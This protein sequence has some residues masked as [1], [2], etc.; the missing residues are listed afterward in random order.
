MKILIQGGRVIDPATQTDTVAD[1]AIADGKIMAIG[2]TPPGF[3][4]DTTIRAKGLVVAPGLVVAGTDSRH[5]EGVADQVYRFMPIRFKREDLARVH[6]TDERISIAQ[7]AD[8]VRFYHR[9]LQQAA[10]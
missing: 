2:A 1:V 7:L 10:Q 9:L 8:M 6:G 4:P 3:V 5:F